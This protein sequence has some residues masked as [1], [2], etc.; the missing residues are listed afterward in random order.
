M[1]KFAANVSFMFT[2]VPFLE[3]FAAA[4]EAGFKGCEFLFPYDHVPDVVAKAVLDAGVTPVLFNG[5]AG[6][7]DKGDRGFAARPG[8]EAEFRA[9]MDQ[10][11][12]YAGAIGNKRLHI[13]AG[14]ADRLDDDARQTYLRNLD[15]AAKRLE[16][17]GITGLIEPINPIDMPGYFLRDISAAIAILRELDTAQIKVQFDCYHRAMQGQDVIEGLEAAAPF[18]DHVQIAGA[19]GRHEPD[20]GEL[21]YGLIFAHLTA[22]GYTGWIGC[23][24]RPK[25]D[26]TAGLGWLAD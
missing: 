10:A 14:L 2:E 13:M 17:H 15:W 7:W 26:T 1:L 3:R 16:P 9:S 22:I 11:I 12:E 5:S 23:E 21:E 18:M 6:D 20:T 4:A 25:G 8:F 24:Y 19:P